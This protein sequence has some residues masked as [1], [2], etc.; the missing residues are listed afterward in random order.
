MSWVPKN[1]SQVECSLGGLTICRTKHIVVLTAKINCSEKIESKARKQ[2]KVHRA[3][4]GGNEAQVSKSPFS[5][6]T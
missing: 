6:I 2:K 3:K 1:N 5:G 4:S